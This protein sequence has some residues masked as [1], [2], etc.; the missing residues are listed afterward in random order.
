MLLPALLPAG[1]PQLCWSQELPKKQVLIDLLAHHEEPEQESI[2]FSSDSSE[3]FAMRLSIFD[4]PNSPKRSPISFPNIYVATIPS[5]HNVI[6][7]SFYQPV[8]NHPLHQYF[9]MARLLL[10]NEVK[11]HQTTP[12]VN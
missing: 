7:Y 1:A 11:Y 6:A 10:S 2:A 8:G 4:P 3:H 12:S 5:N 9:P